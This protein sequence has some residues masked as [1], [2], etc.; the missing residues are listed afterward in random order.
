MNFRD[1]LHAIETTHALE[2]IGIGHEPKGAQVALPCPNKCEGSAVMKT[3]GNKK[4]RMLAAAGGTWLTRKDLG[5]LPALEGRHAEAVELLH[6]ALR[7][8][9]NHVEQGK[10]G[11]RRLRRPA[12]NV[13]LLCKR[14]GRSGA[15]RQH[16]RGA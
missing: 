14:V 11:Q 8:R 10:D 7:L 6:E 16:G 1:T 5:I 3:Y 12:S 13:Y 4:N 15:H 2:I 9:P